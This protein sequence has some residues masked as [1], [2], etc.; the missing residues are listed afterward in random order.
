[1]RGLSP[2]DL[3][4]LASWLID[5]HNAARAPKIAEGCAQLFP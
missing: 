3:R 1:M 4:S 5:S 2:A